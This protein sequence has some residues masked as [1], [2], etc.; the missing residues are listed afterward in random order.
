MHG[1]MQF[2]GFGP[3]VCADALGPDRPL[4]QVAG[5]APTPLFGRVTLADELI[6]R[7]R[8]HPYRQRLDA[9]E[10]GSTLLGEEIHGCTSRLRL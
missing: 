6:E 4:H 7:R 9:I 10:S 8:P 3:D 1:V 2:W 5:K